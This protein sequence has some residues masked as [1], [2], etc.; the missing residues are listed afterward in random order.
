MIERY[1]TP[2]MRRIWSDQNRFATWLEVETTALEV[3]AD[4]GLAPQSSAQAVR[5]KGA[6]DVERIHEIEREVDHDVIAF[7]TCVAEHVGPEAGYLHRGMTSS[8][9]LDTALALQLREAGQAARASL[10]S[11]HASCGDLARR[12][13][14][15]RA[16]GRT[17]GVHAEPLTLGLKF[18]GWYAELGRGIDR[19]DREIDEV[20]CGKISGAV[21]TFAHL[22][23]EVE[24]QVCERLGLRPDPISTQVISRDRHAGFLCALAVLGSTMDRMATEI[25]HLSRTEVLEV[26]EPFGRKQKGSSA[27]PHKRNP[28]T[29]ERITGMARLLRGNCGVGLENVPLWHERDISHSSVERVILPDS[30]GLVHYMAG[31]LERVLRELRIYPENAQRNL[32]LSAGIVASQSF[33]LALV[34][35]GLTREDAYAIVQGV[36]MRAREAGHAFL[37]EALVCPALQERMDESVMRELASMDRHFRHVGTLFERVGL[38]D[39]GTDE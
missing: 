3:M 8:D 24:A 11:L 21:G 27:M 20:A 7:L 32:D 4:M 12:T 28:I 39:D 23:P 26:E 5:A 36:A 37:D 17:H 38:G 34:D 1:T 22:P 25:R 2:E 18:A 19:L 33:L 13:K 30:T 10:S 9:L 15:I 6:F 14:N 31:R 29:C 16:M 35:R